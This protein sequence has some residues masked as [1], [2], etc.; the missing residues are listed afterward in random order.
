MF[1]T[2]APF[3]LQLIA[4]GALIV[5]GLVLYF[6]LAHVTGAQPMGMLL[7]RLRRAA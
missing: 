7:R 6:A 3:I 1:A 2:S 4:L 5:V